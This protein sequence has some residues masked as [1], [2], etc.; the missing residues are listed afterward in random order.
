V[1]LEAPIASGTPHT[2]EGDS[3]HYLS[4][5]LRLREG[6]RLT[7]FDGRGGE[8]AAVVESMGRTRTVVRPGEKVDIERESP[9]EIRLAQGI[10]RGER[11]DF[12]IQKAVELGVSSIVPLLTHR[13]VVRLEPARA[14]RR[15]EHWRGIIIHACQ[16][17]G[18][19]RIPELRP[20]TTME[21]WL[22]DYQA[23]ALDLLLDPDAGLGLSDVDYAG[24]AITLLI[25]P[26]GGFSDDEARWAR[27]AG[28]RGINVGPRILR[29]ETAAVAGLAAIQ[30][31]WGDLGG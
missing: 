2:L 15:H 20:V 8:Y 9:I 22:G 18:R 24:G 21:S 19:N 23:G 1:Y 7:L 17:C 28:F 31:R 14:R 29:T 25:G 27:A 26:E 4:R 3:H 6:A 11:S 12:A 5:V 13:G 10:G 16:Q 30:T